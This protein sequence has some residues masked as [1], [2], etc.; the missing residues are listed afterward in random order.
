M[1]LTNFAFGCS[2]DSSIGADNYIEIPYTI[3]HAYT[4]NDVIDIEKIEKIL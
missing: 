1:V 2:K 3:Q 4:N